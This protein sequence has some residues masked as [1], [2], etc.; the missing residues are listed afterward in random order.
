MPGGELIAAAG[1]GLSVAAILALKRRIGQEWF[2]SG[3]VLPAP[4]SGPKGGA[5]KVVERGTVGRGLMLNR[6]TRC[7]TMPAGATRDAQCARS[8][9]RVTPHWGVDIV[10]NR[11]TPVYAVKSGRISSARVYSGYGNAILLAHEGGRQSTL[12]GHLNRMLVSTGDAVEAGQQIGEVGN[13]G[14]SAGPHLHFEVHNYP[15]PNLTQPRLDP[16]VWLRQ[17]GIQPVGTDTG[18]VAN[19]VYPDED[20]GPGSPSSVS[21]STALADFS[22]PP[23]VAA[24]AVGIAAFAGVAF[25]VGMLKKEKEIYY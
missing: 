16:L 23:A 24:V 18:P 4:F 7:C 25:L 21:V 12:Y 2:A 11:G 9:C 15:E 10:A 3:G 14:M 20:T 8:P 1:A 6:R 17:Q 13:T 19:F 22:M 5:D